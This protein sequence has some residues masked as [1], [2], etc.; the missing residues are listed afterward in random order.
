MNQ[1]DLAG[2][3]ARFL[4]IGRRACADIDDRDVLH[5]SQ[6][7][8]PRHRNT[9]HAEGQKARFLRR[10]RGIE[11]VGGGRGHLG[12][13]FGPGIWNGEPFGVNAVGA[14]GG[15]S[16]HS[17]GD[18]VLHRDCAGDASADLVG[19]PVK[20]GLQRRRLKRAWIT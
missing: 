5:R 18:R 4:E 19:E 2:D 16:L 17:P 15:E 11:L 9:A 10:L 13:A 6:R 1:H 12:R 3:V 8:S 14:G 7:R 20:I